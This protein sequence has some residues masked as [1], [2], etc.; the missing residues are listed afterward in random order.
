V[1][2]CISPSIDILKKQYGHDI[3][4]MIGEIQ[5]NI[6]ILSSVEFLPNVESRFMTGGPIPFTADLMSDA[7]YLH[8]VPNQ[9]LYWVAKFQKDIKYLG[10]SGKKMPT[11]FSVFV[12][13]RNPYWIPILREL[14]DYVKDTSD[15]GNFQVKTFFGRSNVPPDVREY[16]A[17]ICS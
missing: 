11:Q 12:M 9:E 16:L 17:L 10:T 8:F 7:E 14:R 15:A 2:G 6:G 1:R 4:S 3:E 13:E 5:R